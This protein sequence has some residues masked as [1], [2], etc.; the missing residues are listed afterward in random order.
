MRFMVPPHLCQALTGLPVMG[1]QGQPL[2]GH[3]ERKVVVNSQQTAPQLPP[4]HPG[5]GCVPHCTISGSA[6]RSCLLKAQHGRPCSSQGQDWLTMA[7]MLSARPWR[8]AHVFTLRKM[9][10]K[11]QRAQRVHK[12]QREHPMWT[13]AGIAVTPLP[14]RLSA[15]GLGQQ[16][17]MT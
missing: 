9:F 5:T 15:A 16:R 14:V 12:T 17:R 1:L 11:V 3:L 7:T 6:L 10:L 2:S 13:P 4:C 8:R